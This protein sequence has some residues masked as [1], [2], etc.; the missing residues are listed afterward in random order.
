MLF[1]G[2][3]GYV[4]PPD[5]DHTPFSNDFCCRKGCTHNS[6]HAL[7][8]VDTRHPNVARQHSE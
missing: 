8:L 6:S 3:R 7:L 5:I 4:Y 1:L 2:D